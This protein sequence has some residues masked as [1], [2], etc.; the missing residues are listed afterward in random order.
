M[1][2][3]RLS[4]TFSSS[5]SSLLHSLSHPFPP[6]SHPQLLPFF[7]PWNSF[8]DSTS[9][10]ESM[11][12]VFFQFT[13]FPPFFHSQKTPFTFP[14][15]PSNSH[16]FHISFWHLLHRFYLPLAAMFSFV[17]PTL[18]PWYFWNE[19]LMTAYM[20]AAMAR[21]CV[22]LHITWLVT[23]FDTFFL[24]YTVWCILFFDTFFFGS[25]F[26]LMHSSNILFLDT[27]WLI[28][29]QK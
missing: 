10:F 22:S 24:W 19:K 3:S 23:F 15:F 29:M 12:V 25:F 5:S 17:I 20:M 21:Y 8:L 6:F 2:S 28:Y 18:I 11:N 14:L 27:F 4:I 26:S 16:C 13:I 7:S 1:L 9:C